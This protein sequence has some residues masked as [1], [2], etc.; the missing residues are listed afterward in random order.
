MQWDEPLPVLP[1]G[2][3]QVTRVFESS[4]KPVRVAPPGSKLVRIAQRVAQAVT[5]EAAATGFGQ[6]VL[7]QGWHLFVI[8][9]D[10][11]ETDHLVSEQYYNAIIINRRL[12]LT[13]KRH[14]GHT[15]E[16]IM[17]E[18]ALHMSHHLAQHM[19]RDR[20]FACAERQWQHCQAAGVASMAGA[21]VHA[22]RMLLVGAPMQ[23]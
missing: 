17:Q 14:S 11:C 22:M 15:E 1:A 6:H 8:S 18:L 16:A 2:S 12:M 23:D 21:C 5:E 19:V 13:F 4:S 10:E 7:S 9:T 20:R 3:V